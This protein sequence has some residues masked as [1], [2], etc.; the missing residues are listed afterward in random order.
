V[1]AVERAGLPPLRFHDLRHTCA[2]LLIAQGAHPKAICERLGHSG[3]D[4]TMD[5]YGHLFASVAEALAEAL[6]ELWSHSQQT[7]PLAGVA[8]L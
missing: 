2:A 3:I 5:T 8:S 4:V 1:P 7:A 6:D